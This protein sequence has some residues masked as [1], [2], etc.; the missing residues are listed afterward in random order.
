MNRKPSHRT[1]LLL[2]LAVGLGVRLLLAPFT[3]HPFDMYVWHQ[4][5]A[6]DIA[7]Q[8]PVYA[9]SPMMS[10]T[11]YVVS[12][13]YRILR[14]VFGVSPMPVSS[15]SV[16]MRSAIGWTTPP[17][18]TVSVVTDP[19]F[20]MLVKLPFIISDVVAG[21]LLYRLVSRFWGMN[22]GLLAFS[23]WFLN[24]MLIWVSAVW[25]MFD[26]LPALFSVL[27]IYFIETK[28]SLWA[29]TSL[30][31]ATGY[32]LYPLLFTLPILL[33]LCKNGFSFDFL[34]R[35][36]ISFVL[37]SV[38]IFT[39]FFTKT[40]EAATGIVSPGADI[41]NSAFGLTYWSLAP[42]VTSNVA[43]V[44]LASNFLFLALI[45]AAILTL[46]RRGLVGGTKDLQYGVL[47]MLSTIFL[48]RNVIPEQFF[49]WLLPSLVML[50][51]VGLPQRYLWT[52]SV[53]SLF[54]SW[55]NSL[56]TAFAA[57]ML[58]LGSEIYLNSLASAWAAFS[59]LRLLNM[60]VLG[61]AFSIVLTFVV[62]GKRW[63]QYIAS[64]LRW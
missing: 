12:F 48:S 26:S 52:L 27:A 14:D 42:L 62:A 55:A 18:A 31:V 57:P 29:G 2:I 33:H 20:N 28:R 39:P 64:V 4:A 45:S 47:L 6:Q 9:T 41:A 56:F 10:Y 37:V 40:W 24:P 34:R 43:G 30:A 54:Y 5:V 23:L 49:V 19:L 44:S 15:L 7:G 63:M 22:K 38:L 11:L 61:T 32:K 25:G 17:G 35:A 51:F 3:G 36:T 13:P 1:L 60:A 58:V 59:G 8:G 50:T 46:T 16:E 21:F 53:L